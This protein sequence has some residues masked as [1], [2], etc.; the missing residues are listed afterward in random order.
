[1]ARWTWMVMGAA[2]ATVIAAGPARADKVTLKNGDVLHGDVEE[3]GGRVR[4]KHP[5]LGDVD[6]AKAGVMWIQKE[7]APPPPPAP[8]T[9]LCDR[10]AKCIEDFCV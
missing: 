2:L 6:L 3:H 10:C 7:G 8:A 9:A 5:I 1:M 4:V